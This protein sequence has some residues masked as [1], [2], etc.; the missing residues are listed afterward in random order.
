[1][2]GDPTLGVEGGNGELPGE[3]DWKGRFIAGGLGVTG[4][5]GRPYDPLGD[6]NV[7]EGDET[8]PGP[9]PLPPP[10]ELGPL[11]DHPFG[12]AARACGARSG[13]GSAGGRTKPV[14][15]EAVGVGV[16]P[17]DWVLEAVDV[18]SVVL[19]L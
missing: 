1:M 3:R 8:R 4:G 5:V 9:L 17:L 18:D 10:I 6:P 14:L 16:V 15:M 12:I 2:V 19:C 7:V 11:V 13:V